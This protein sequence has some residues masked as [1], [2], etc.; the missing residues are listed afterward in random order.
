MGSQCYRYKMRGRL[1]STSTQSSSRYSTVYSAP[2]LRPCRTHRNINQPHGTTT[3]TENT[4]TANTC[5]NKHRQQN[6]ATFLQTPLPHPTGTLH[7]SNLVLTYICFA[8][9]PA[10]HLVPATLVTLGSHVHTNTAILCFMF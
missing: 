5:Y 7:S 6:N 9:Q 10:S 2:P 8:F 3:P 4:G 1:E